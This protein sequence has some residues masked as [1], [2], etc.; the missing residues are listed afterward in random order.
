MLN[1]YF[2]CIYVINLKRRPDRLAHITEQLMQVNTAFK[3]IDAVDGNDVKCNLKVGNGWNYKG[4]TGC[5]YSHKKVYEDALGNNFKRILVVEDD[6]IFAD[7]VNLK[8]IGS[9]F[10]NFPILNPNRNTMSTCI[11]SQIFSLQE[12]SSAY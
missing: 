10:I 3:L 6:N 12:Q 8:S 2:D 5:A 9:I 1:K 4:V 7:K 11:G